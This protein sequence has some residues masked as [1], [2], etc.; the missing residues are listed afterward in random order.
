MDYNIIRPPVGFSQY[1]EYYWNIL[2]CIIAPILRY[3]IIV[4]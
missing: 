1:S 2:N 4:I 3:N